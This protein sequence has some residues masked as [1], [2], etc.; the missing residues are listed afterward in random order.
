M[1]ACQM[2]HLVISIVRV[3]VSATS[4]LVVVAISLCVGGIIILAAGF[5]FICRCVTNQ[6]FYLHT[7]GGVYPPPLT[8]ED[9]PWL[10]TVITPL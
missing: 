4:V 6:G 3:C 2:T 7:L 8:L 5:I 9:T 10:C 1:S